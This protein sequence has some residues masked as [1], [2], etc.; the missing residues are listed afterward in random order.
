MNSLKLRR[1][2]VPEKGASLS[3][4]LQAGPSVGFVDLSIIGVPQ[5][6]LSRLPVPSA[7]PQKYNLDAKPIWDALVTNPVWRAELRTL[8]L[9]QAWNKTI[10][11]F[12]VLASRNGVLPFAN[13]TNIAQNDYIKDFV[14]RARRHIVEY[15]NEI[16]LFKKVR[17]RRTFREYK[18][19]THGLVIRSWFEPYVIQDPDFEKWLQT[20]PLPRFWKKDNNTYF[21]IVRP[22]VHMWVKFI[23][24]NRVIIGF[25][26]D[27]A[28]TVNLM[29]K[30]TPTQQE[31][32]A[33]IDRTIYFPVIRANRFRG[34][35]TRLF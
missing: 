8:R 6:Y 10:I 4:T 3:N 5:R 32:D 26:I 35:H 18:R 29:G 15:V 33:F 34:V 24:R 30:K 21:R 9:D 13:N 14:S 27:V 17:I 7:F 1:N 31:V 25:Q 19:K 2:G 20:S 11:K 12:L 22:H 23:N 28:G 16:G